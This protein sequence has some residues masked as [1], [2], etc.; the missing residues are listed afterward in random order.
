MLAMKNKPFA[1]VLIVLGTGLITVMANGCTPPSQLIE[2][3]VARIS[4]YG[5]E[6]ERAQKELKDA[7]K[8]A[9][10]E[11]IQRYRTAKNVLE[12]AMKASHFPP[13][14]QLQLRRC[15][16]KDLQQEVLIPAARPPSHDDAVFAG[17][18]LQ[19]GQ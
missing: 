18:L 16:G 19:Q 15:A 5:N 13:Q 6:L 8:V 4:R 3:F 1:V 11:A 7:E 2:E 10:K 17:M 12:N 9:L 14:G